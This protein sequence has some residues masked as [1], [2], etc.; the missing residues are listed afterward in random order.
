MSDLQHGCHDRLNYR[1]LSTVFLPVAASGQQRYF[2][3]MEMKAILK[4]I[5]RRLVA[6][7]MK[8]AAASRLATGSPDVIRNWERGVREG[9]NPGASTGTLSALAGVLKTNVPWLV[10]GVGPEV[11][12]PIDLAVTEAPLVSWVSAGQLSS[13]DA[14]DAAIGTARAVLGSGDWIAMR[15]EG[16]SMDR[17]SPPGSI[18]FVDRLDK[19]LVTGGFYVIDDGEGNATYKRFVM[20]RGRMKFEPVSKNKDLAAIYPENEPTIVGRVKLTTLDLM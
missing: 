20:D 8:A 1:F 13:D 17:I 3:R 11:G 15:V 2:H 19:R 10:D 7:E 6:L 9:K 14:I 18:I 4:R 12:E 5:Q 16:E